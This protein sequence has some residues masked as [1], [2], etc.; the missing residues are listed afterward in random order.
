M[1]GQAGRQ[2][3]TEVSCTPCM[4]SICCCLCHHH[5][6]CLSCCTVD[7]VCAARLLHCPPTRETVRLAAAPLTQRLQHRHRLLLHA[8][9]I[10]KVCLL[11]KGVRDDTRHKCLAG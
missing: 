8:R 6:R 3:G 11:P 7:S 2:A 9:E 5:C 4:H 1:G 10:Q